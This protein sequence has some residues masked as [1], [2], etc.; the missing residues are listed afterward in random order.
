MR[1]TTQDYIK[2]MCS[3]IYD[4]CSQWVPCVWVRRTHSSRSKNYWDRAKK[5]AKTVQ[6]LKAVK[7]SLAAVSVNIRL[8][9][10]ANGKTL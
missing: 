9:T 6:N 2:R 5:I 10:N 8:W 3:T 7:N 1:K 4:V